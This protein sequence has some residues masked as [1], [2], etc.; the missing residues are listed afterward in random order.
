M[1][2]ANGYT[3]FTEL[4]VLVNDMAWISYLHIWQSSEQFSLAF[5]C[6]IIH[7]VKVHFLCTL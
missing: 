5:S 4:G 7:E 6:L 3:P 1:E 2:L